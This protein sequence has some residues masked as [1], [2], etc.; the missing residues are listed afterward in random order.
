MTP[1]CERQKRHY[2][3][4]KGEDVIVCVPGARIEHV[5]ERVENTL[6][7][8][9]GGS[10]L[11]HVGMNN[12]DMEGTTRIVQGYRQLVGKLKKTRV[13]QTILSGILLV[14]GGRGATYRILQEDG[15]QRCSRADV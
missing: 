9:Q 14:M 15:N 10:V 8:G 3:V 12:A 5:T 1:F 7:H 6:G 13:E 4:S 2:L 11:V